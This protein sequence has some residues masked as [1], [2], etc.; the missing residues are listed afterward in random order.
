VDRSNKPT[1]YEGWVCLTLAIGETEESYEA[2][3]HEWL[4]LHENPAGDKGKQTSELNYLLERKA[5]PAPS[6]FQVENSVHAAAQKGNV[7]AIAAIAAGP[8]CVD[9]N[10]QDSQG[11][12]A[13]HYAAAEG[14][15]SA[16]C[17][18]AQRRAHLAISTIDGETPLVLAV[19]YGHIDAV[20]ELVDA[21][22][23][24]N[25]FDPNGPSPLVAAVRQGDVEMVKL[26]LAL[27][28]DVSL[29]DGYQMTPLVAAAFEGDDS[30]DGVLAELISAGADVNL[31]APS[32]LSA[33]EVAA[34]QG[35]LRAAKKLMDHGADPNGRPPLLS[36][37]QYAI[38]ERNVSMAEALLDRGAQLAGPGGRFEHGWTALM[39]AAATGDVAM[40]RL[41]LS[42]GAEMYAVA[43]DEKWTALHVAAARGNKLFFKWLQKESENSGH[44]WGELDWQGRSA[45]QLRTWKTV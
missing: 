13:L 8:G 33:L 22:A 38:D 39:C 7:N 5:Q 25:Y 12:T 11:W 15:S 36:P 14:H 2:A 16:V 1:R 24:V 3:K 19:V 44:G 45:F 21:G 9:L 27:N 10:A 28:A 20:C 35:N 23:D 29:A 17:A 43:G 42:R 26:L 32:G 41:L 34:R 37:L 30:D 18:L 40:G 4:L 31:H 6:G